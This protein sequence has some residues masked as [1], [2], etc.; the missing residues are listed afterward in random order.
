MEAKFLSD[1]IYKDLM[2]GNLI[3]LY[4][5]FGFYSKDLDM[6]IWAPTGFICDLESTPVVKGSSK[7]GGV[8]HDY[9]CRIDSIPS[10]TKQQA[11]SLYIEMQKCKDLL[12]NEGWFKRID[13]MFRRNFKTLI[14]RVWPGY[15]HKL[16][17]M[18][19]LEEVSKT[20]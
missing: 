20:V 9:A 8:G 6:E 13:R 12:L 5:P 3:Q 17:V 10:F 15:F 11:A 18:A 19:T 7:R 1:L 14:V 2:C 4:E 16:T